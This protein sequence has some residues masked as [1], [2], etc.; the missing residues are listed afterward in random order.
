MQPTSQRREEFQQNSLRPSMGLQVYKYEASPFV[1][2]V[3]M[4]CSFSSQQHILNTRLVIPDSSKPIKPSE[5]FA[6]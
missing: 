4:I 5:L 2:Y 1:F 3:D 6:F